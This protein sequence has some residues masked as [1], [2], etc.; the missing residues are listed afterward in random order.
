MASQAA[1]TLAAVRPLYRRPPT[2]HF[3]D[4]NRIDMTAARVTSERTGIENAPT[5]GIFRAKEHR[6][7]EG[8]SSNRH[9]RPG[10]LIAGRLQ[11]PHATW[12]TERICRGA[13]EQCAAS[14]RVGWLGFPVSGRRSSCGETS[15]LRKAG[16]RVY[17]LCRLRRG[18]SPP[19][20]LVGASHKTACP[21]MGRAG[22]QS[23]RADQLGAVS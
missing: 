5:Y 22:A 4:K 11:T 18:R 12:A 10:R 19:L 7:R 13:S 16:V 17:G 2:R 8:R 15:R 1:S 3:P 20:H 23:L 14:R 6:K 21:A 9:D